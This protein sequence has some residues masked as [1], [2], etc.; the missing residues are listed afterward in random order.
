MTIR[1]FV[2]SRLHVAARNR[3][4]FFAYRAVGDWIDSSFRALK[5]ETQL[6][7][8]SFSHNGANSWSCSCSRYT[9]DINRE[10]KHA[11]VFSSR[12]KLKRYRKIGTTEEKVKFVFPSFQLYRPTRC[13]V[14][15]ERA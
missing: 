5:L 7:S 8:V 13:S 9:I 10:C 15:E 14:E 2:D 3:H 1:Y 12:E 4:S 6:P 11:L